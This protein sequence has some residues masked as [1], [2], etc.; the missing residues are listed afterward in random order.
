MEKRIVLI[1][2]AF[3]IGVLSYAQE[4][5]SGS[6]IFE[7]RARLEIKIDGEMAAMMKDLPKERSSEKILWFS[8]EASLY[9]NYENDASDKTGGM[10][11]GEGNVNIVMQEPDNKLFVDLEKKKIIEQREFLTRMFLIE[12]DMPEKE[13]KIT[14]GQEVIL[15]YPCIEATNTDT[16]GVVTR[17]WFAPALNIPA[18]PGYYCNLPGIV[19]KVD[20]DNG[21]RILEASKI[22]LDK[23]G[24]DVF[25]KPGKGKKV[26]KEEFDAIVAEKMEEMGAEGGQGSGNMVIINIRK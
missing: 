24:D 7:D 1:A 6:V 8:P 18:G 11:H 4:L 5:N 15:D 2:T 19:L 17:I 23:P 22:S 20:I 26:S 3:F 9:E 16:S 21:K 10:W 13:W 14:G 25:K 12:G